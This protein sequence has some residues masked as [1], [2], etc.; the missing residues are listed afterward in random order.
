MDGRKMKIEDIKNE[1]ISSGH[2]TQDEINNMKL[3][4]KSEWMDLYNTCTTSY[5][6]DGGTENSINVIKEP[7]AKKDTKPGIPRYCDKEWHDYV[8]SQFSEKEIIDE[9]YPSV[10]GLRRVTELL[11][12]DII[13]SGPI[14]VQT[15]MS[16]TMKDKSVVT[17]EVTIRWKLDALFDTHVTFNEPEEVYPIR[18]FKSVASSHINNTDDAYSVFSEAI[19]ETRAEGRTLRRALG[20]NVV[21]A[22][23]L[24]KKDTARLIQEQ[25]DQQTTDGDWEEESL[26]TEQQIKTISLLS[27]RL[28]IDVNKFINSGSLKYDNIEQIP[29]KS[30]AGMLKQ[31]NRYQSS[32]EDSI[33]IPK[34]LLKGGEE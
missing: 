15:T 29:R 14:N 22:D 26:I 33:E 3:K 34:E 19:A 21:C 18:K 2:Y 16:G 10:G 25:Q 17:Y 20:L 1:L 8:M 30:A 5:Q 11:L 4:G 28:G 7:E 9:K 31:L 6:F 12:G 27:D 32:G 24:T 13:D 23:E